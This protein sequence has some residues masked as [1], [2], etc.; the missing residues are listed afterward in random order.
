M[1]RSIPPTVGQAA[2][3]KAFTKGVKGM[4]TR[5]VQ[6][7]NGSYFINIPSVVR[8]EMG[9]EKGDPLKIGYLAGCGILITKDKGTDEI[10][11]NLESE[12]RLKR[13]ADNIF[14]E[15]R[16][17]AKSVERSFT[18]NIMTRLIGELLKSGL[19]NLTPALNAFLI[20]DSDQ[21]KNQ[22]GLTEGSS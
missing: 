21:D 20:N 2:T 8:D 14:S 18:T 16:R 22:K 4:E 19:I 12:D 7:I 15:F 9:I 6:K 10:S 1:V 13:T 11:I 5:K 3:H 17:K